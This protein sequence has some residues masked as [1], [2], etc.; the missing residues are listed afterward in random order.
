DVH[1][2]ANIANWTRWTFNGYHNAPTCTPAT[3]HLPFAY[4]FPFAGKYTIIVDVLDHEGLPICS[5][6]MSFAHATG[7]DGVYFND[8][9]TSHTRNNLPSCDTTY[10]NHDILFLNVK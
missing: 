3:C 7:G 4:D 1:T 8:K 5:G 2:L 10:S 6:Y 9:N